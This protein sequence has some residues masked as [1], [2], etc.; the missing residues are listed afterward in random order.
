MH[1]YVLRRRNT[2]SH[3]IAFDVHHRDGDIL[4]NLRRLADFPS[5]NASETTRK[6]CYR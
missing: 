6:I 1:L 3:L 5:Q 2:Y 4:T